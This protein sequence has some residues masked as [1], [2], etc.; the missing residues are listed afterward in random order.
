VQVAAQDTPLRKAL[1]GL[2]TASAGGTTSCEPP[3]STFDPDT[4]NG[5]TSGCIDTTGGIALFGVPTSP[6]ATHEVA[7]EHATE[8]N[9]LAEPITE[10]TTG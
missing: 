7:L 9:S 3:K 4:V 2:I 6:T 1:S 5:T 8:R 10:T